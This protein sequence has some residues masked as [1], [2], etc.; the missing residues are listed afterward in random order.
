MKYFILF[1]SL[2]SCS[3]WGQTNYGTFSGKVTDEQ[4]APLLSANVVILETSNGTS[5]DK[6][7]KFRII[8]KPGSYNIEI[9]FI[10]YDKI[11]DNISIRVGEVFDKSYKMKSNSFTIGTITVTADNDFI[12][13]SPET[14]TNVSS[15]EIEHMLASSLN[16][17]MKLMPGVETTNPTLNN[18]EQA[19]IRNGDAL[20]TQII[21]NGIPISNNANMQIGIGTSTANSGTDLRSI[22][23]ENVKDIDIIRGIP[24]AKYGDLTDG[25]L[26]VN[27]KASADPLKVKLKYNPQLYET[28]IS[29]GTY[30]SD[31]IVN[32]NLNIASSDRDVRISGDGYTRVAAQ[33]TFENTSENFNFQNVF[34]FTH[35][36]DDYKEQ[37]GYAL[38]Q[39]WYN[40]DI[41]LKYSADYSRIF[42]SFTQL[43]A[44]LSVSYTNQNSYD[45][46]L[47]SRDNIV[48]TDRTIEGAQQGRIVFGSYLGKK[49]INGDVWNIYSDVNYNSKFFTA[50]YLHSLLYGITYR[51]DFNK[52][53]GIYFDPLF[54]PNATTTTPRL[55]NYS[56]IPSYNILSFYAEDKLTGNLIKPFILQAGFRYETYRPKG[57]DLKGLIGKGDLIK[58][59]N[60]SF[61][62]PRVN[63]SMNI[64]KD[65][66]IRFGYGVTS[67]SP[68]MGMIFADKKYY[69]IVDTVSVVNPQYADSNFSMISTYIREQANSQI[70]GYTQKK[71]EVSFDQQFDF[72]GFSVT[73]YYNDSRNMFQSIEIPTIV[74]KQAFPD[75]LNLANSYNKDTL[76]ES[77]LQYANNGWLK[78]KGIEFTLTTRKIPVINTVFKFD[79]AYTYTEYGANNGYYYDSPRYVSTLGEDLMP[80]YH[81]YYN[82]SKDLLLNYRFDIQAKSL[83]IWLT[84]HIQQKVIEIDG[85]NGYDNIMAA[86]YYTSKGELIIIPESERSSPK[87][88]AIQRS[89][90]SFELNQE[91]KPNKWL[92]N[93]KV[94]KSLWSGTAVSFFVNNFFNN[95]PLYQIR[96]SSP[97]TPSYETRNP[98][99][100]YG[101]D[102]SVSL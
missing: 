41:N 17:A 100:F 14:K 70:K 40:H 47:V 62:N 32:G 65:S 57:F 30:L 78:V 37:P 51:N 31:W 93:L 80:L 48:I 24:S 25:L 19:T 77:Y 56:S 55:R 101:L 97:S 60:G 42:D 63:F 35:S 53:N 84:L 6:N 33:L 64:L 50:E 98:E 99:M 79:A 72:M 21:L 81:Q 7:G 58:S 18:T 11:S 44:K 49:Y 29:G 1:L 66:Q 3:L 88:A 36:F 8:S 43:S 61:L 4:G 39:A 92:F 94:S 28:N 9:T 95:Q 12:P 46:Q 52:G 22:P 87:Y 26:I 67:K 91:N 54:P 89:I 5:T 68:P 23:A 73:G 86:G 82:Y 83:G 2:L 10:G 16:D 71:Y 34:Y 75:P 85:R 76:L 74:Y 20:G 59:N 38:R 102:F 27:T 45:Q 13:L 15:A 96:R 90:Q 69:D